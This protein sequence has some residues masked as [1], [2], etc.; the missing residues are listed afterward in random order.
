VAQ[1]RSSIRLHSSAGN[2]RRV[3]VLVTDLVTGQASPRRRKSQLLL[4]L[5]PGIDLL[6]R[7]FEAEGFCVVRGPDLIWGQSIEDFHVPAG[8]FDGIIAGSPCQGFSRIN[9]NPDRAKSESALNE[10]RRL[11]TEA[12][13]DWFLLENVPSVPDVVIEG[14]RIQRFDLN[15]RE[16][17]SRQSR[18]RHFQWGSK[19]GVVLI[20]ERGRLTDEVEPCCL[21]TEGKRTLRRSFADFCELQ[22]LPRDFDLPGWPIK[23]KYAAV[24][25]G[26]HVNVARVIARAVVNARWVTARSQSHLRLCVCRCGRIV[27]GRQAAALPACRKRMQRRRELAIAERAGGVTPTRETLDVTKPGPVTLDESH[28]AAA[29]ETKAAA[30]DR[31]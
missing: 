19:R 31:L 21:A 22:G 29:A 12:Q 9:R 6:G 23:F 20:L 4:S 15:A 27:T 18:L 24:G 13:P 5:F 3:T 2:R 8:R 28:F 11:V 7:G 16:C 25:N 17:G 1:K 26:V 30:I 10:F 14:Y